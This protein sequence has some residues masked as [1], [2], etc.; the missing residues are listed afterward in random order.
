MKGFVACA[1][2]AFI[3][4]KQLKLTNPLYLALSYDEEIGCLGVRSLIDMMEDLKY[5]PSMCIVGEP[6]MLKI[7][8]ANKGVEIIE[9][10]LGIIL[11]FSNKLVIVTLVLLKSLKDKLV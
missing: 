11:L 2:N 10:I 6:T 9:T 4:A 8:S 5:K 7:V 1:L 3:K